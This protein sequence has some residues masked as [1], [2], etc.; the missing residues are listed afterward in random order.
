MTESFVFF[1]IFK[2]IQKEKN[3]G[4][5]LIVTASEMDGESENWEVGDEVHKG[6]SFRYA[7]G[8]MDDGS[9]LNEGCGVDFLWP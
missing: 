1:D 8:V 5:R 9:Y 2:P 6:A 3:H 4:I 7:D